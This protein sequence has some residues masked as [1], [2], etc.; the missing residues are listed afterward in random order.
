MQSTPQGLHQNNG[1]QVNLSALDHQSDSLEVSNSLCDKNDFCNS[2]IEC[3]NYS[4]TIN[5]HIE[6]VTFTSH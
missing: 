3:C 4:L 6:D 5:K 2:Y 1:Q